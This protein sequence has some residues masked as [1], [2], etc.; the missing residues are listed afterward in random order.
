MLNTVL[1]SIVIPLPC[2]PGMSKTSL[3]QVSSAKQLVAHRGKGM[4]IMAFHFS[5]DYYYYCIADDDS[6]TADDCESSVTE[7]DDPWPEDEDAESDESDEGD[8][9]DENTN[10]LGNKSVARP[11]TA[12]EKRF[13]AE[14]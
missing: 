3:S 1:E 10:V 11:L 5:N 8:S 6:D 2:V 12:A 9:D 13:M 14:V 4:Y 7:S